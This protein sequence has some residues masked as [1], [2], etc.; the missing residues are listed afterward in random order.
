MENTTITKWFLIVGKI[1]GYSYLLLVFI[2]MPL[3]YLFHIPQYIRPMGS[4]HGALFVAFMILLALMFFKV[5]LSFKKACLVFL[6]SLVPFGTF[7][8]KRVV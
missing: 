4:I 7:F 2:A 3:K 8:L 1:E 6:L 5:K